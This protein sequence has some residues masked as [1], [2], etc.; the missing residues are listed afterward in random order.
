MKTTLIPPAAAALSFAAF[1]R[2]RN[3]GGAG[4]RRS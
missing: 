2:Q 4:R 3:F 1:A